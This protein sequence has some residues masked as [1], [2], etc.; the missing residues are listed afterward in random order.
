MNKKRKLDTN[1]PD[2]KRRMAAKSSSGDIAEFD[3]EGEEKKEAISSSVSSSNAD[4]NGNGNVDVISCP[5]LD[6]I[7]RKV[8]P[9]CIL[10]RIYV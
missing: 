9:R 4:N 7:N 10:V 1:P 6:T 5:Y 8:F 3:V 2:S